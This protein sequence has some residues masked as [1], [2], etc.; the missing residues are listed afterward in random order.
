VSKQLCLKLLRLSG[1]PSASE[2]KQAYRITKAYQYLIAIKT[3]KVKIP[4]SIK[5]SES[6]RQVY[7]NKNKKYGTHSSWNSEANR[8]AR[9]ASRE[10]AKKEFEKYINSEEYA[11][12]ILF[13][14]FF[15]Y[16]ALI[17]VSLIITLII[18]FIVTQ[19]PYALASVIV[20]GI[21]AFPMWWAYVRLEFHS[22]SF[23]EFK[24]LFSQVSQTHLFWTISLGITNIF[25]LLAF[26]L[27]TVISTNLILMIFIII[28]AGSFILLKYGLNYSK[29]QT[30]HWSLG[31]LPFVVNLLFLIN[32][33]FSG[34]AVTETY[35]FKYTPFESNYD[36]ATDGLIFLPDNKFDD[37][38]YLRAFY[39]NRPQSSGFASYSIAKGL[40]GFDVV[41]DSKLYH[42]LPNDSFQNP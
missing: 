41:K 32:Y 21:I 15:R 4:D 6:S 42:F 22:M 40:F 30:Q 35:Q 38:Y 11:L 36:G 19:K 31:I 20:G 9:E 3:G 34:E 23:S 10:K 28:S 13:S 25:L 2:I 26:T 29:R 27:Y 17:I 37:V 24:K 33:S 14:R 5:N 16:L 18:I 39:M 8:K 12:E 7:S 1:N